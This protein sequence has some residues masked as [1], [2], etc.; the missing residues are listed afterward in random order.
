M[1]IKV[2]FPRALLL[3]FFMMTGILFWDVTN[4]KA[5]DD[6][7]ENMKWSSVLKIESPEC[8]VKE[9]G[10]VG[11]SGTYDTIVEKKGGPV[12]LSISPKEGYAVYYRKFKEDEITN[13]NNPKRLDEAGLIQG[14]ESKE[15]VFV[16]PEEHY[17]GEYEGYPFVYIVLKEKDGKY[18]KADG[19]EFHVETAESEDKTVRWPYGRDAEKL[20][21]GDKSWFFGGVTQTVRE[22]LLLDSVKISNA[23]DTN[24]GEVQFDKNTFWY[25]P[26]VKNGK[27]ITMTTAVDYHLGGS[28]ECKID[29]GEPIYPDSE[30]RITIPGLEKV[31]TSKRVQLETVPKK[32]CEF[33]QASSTYSFTITRIKGNAPLENITVTGTYKPFENFAPE[34]YDYSVAVDQKTEEIVVRVSGSENSTSI[35][36]QIDKGEKQDVPKN[37][38]ITVPITDGGQP[39]L[40]IYTTADADSDLYQDGVYTIQVLQKHSQEELLKRA[41]KT[42]EFYRGLVS[43][44]STLNSVDAVWTIMELKTYGENL[45]AL[46]ITKESYLNSKGLQELISKWDNHG[47]YFQEK[48]VMGLLSVGYTL[49]ELSMFPVGDKTVNLVQE[50]FLNNFSSLWALADDNFRSYLGED[51]VLERALE[52]SKNQKDTGEYI[53][54]HTGGTDGTAMSIQAFSTWYGEN[55]EITASVDKALGYLSSVQNKATG[56]VPYSGYGYYSSETIS[57]WIVAL[58]SLGMDP[59]KAEAFTSDS[60]LGLVDVLIDY[61]MLEDGTFEHIQGQGKNGMATEQAF[62]ALAAYKAF[63]ENKGEKTFVFDLHTTQPWTGTE[64]VAATIKAIDAIGTVSKESGKAIETARTAY[65]ALTEAEQKSMPVRYLEILTKAETAYAPLKPV[66]DTEALIAA[67]GE[68][69]L[70]KEAAIQAAQVAFDALSEEQKKQV[71]NASVLEAASKALAADKATVAQIQEKLNRLLPL[72]NLTTAQEE[73]AKALQQ[74]I[75][76]LRQDMYDAL[77]NADQIDAI[78]QRIEDLKDAEKVEALI[79]AIGTVDSLEDE[80]AVIEAKQA[81]D[82]LGEAKQ[83]LLKEGYKEK[84]DQAVAA[85]Q[86]L[87]NNAAVQNV[88]DNINKLVDENGKVQVSLEDG[89]FLASVRALYDQVD[90]VG[91]G[92]RVT[93]SDILFRAEAIYTKL[94]VKDAADKILALPPNDTITGTAEDGSD[95]VMTEEQLNSILE[96]QTTYEALTDEQKA[97]VGK[98][99]GEE[100]MNN[101]YLDVQ[102]AETYSG[103]IEAVLSVFVQ[104]VMDLELPLTNGD[105]NVAKANLEKAQALIEQYESNEAAQSYLNSLEGFAEK[106]QQIEAEILRVHTDLANAQ[107]VDQMIGALPSSITSDEE[108]EAAQAAVSAIRTAYENL[109][110]DAQN[111]VLRMA[112]VDTVELLIANYDKAKEEAVAVEKVI[113]EALNRAEESLTA[114]GTVEAVK[115]AEKALADASVTA[116]N[117]VSADLK[118]ALAALPERIQGAKAELLQKHEFASI[119]EKLPYDVTVEISLEKSGKEYEALK[120]ALQSKKKAEIAESIRISAYQVVWDEEKQAYAQQAWTPQGGFTITLK[121]D[122]NLSGKEIMVGQYQENGD[123]AYITVTAGEGQVTFKADSLTVYALGLKEKA[124]P[125]DGKGDGNNTGGNNTGGNNAGGNN[126]GGNNAGGNNAGGTNTG[127]GNKGNTPTGSKNTGGTTA[128]GSAGVPKTGDF[129]ADSLGACMALLTVAAVI[130]LAAII[131][132]RKERSR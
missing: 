60:G 52:L 26:N 112:E 40:K 5:G 103:Y 46:G 28:V 107:A 131:A 95:I 73:E 80:A 20:A 110:S 113:Q 32:G 83:A 74:Q 9:D 55:Q 43:S 4:V 8:E 72:E 100:A 124:A 105:I 1:R 7:D 48:A 21:K 14:G 132:R 13:M 58:C 10:Y 44:G 93:N 35:Q 45:E 66:A 64:A 41:E 69:T 6:I 120:D 119:A 104:K 70:E 97:K 125:D 33:D 123:V 99:A 82:A 89:E 76:A 67:I 130:T 12:T 108:R 2:V 23:T 111:Y 27:D 29:G 122:S 62:R 38:K 94:V 81:Y 31:G 117:L 18:Y 65:D 42:A 127:S 30:G 84:L 22:K 53:D 47:G 34:T 59:N 57:Q 98:I 88:I 37:G 54:S 16:L 63:L 92:N 78:V 91:L 71:E 121:T 126:A 129:L 36:Y 15:F 56:L 114:D 109:N 68:V 19:T 118:T 128:G 51:L 96:A 11:Y 75:K 39:L 25:Y 86:E 102:T 50:D 61:F 49:D 106:R 77:E 115:T 79:D 24:G 85:V 87:K 101:Y 17:S 90:A 3:C 116:K